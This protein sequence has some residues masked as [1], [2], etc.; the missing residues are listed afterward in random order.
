MISAIQR[1]RAI[2]ASEKL[3]NREEF[4]RALRWLG[5]KLGARYC[6][7]N[8]AKTGVEEVQAA[9]LRCSRDTWKRTFGEP[10]NVA[11]CHERTAACIPQPRYCWEQP[12]TEGAV[13]CIG[14]MFERLP[15][16]SKAIL[17]EVAFDGGDQAGQEKRN[18]VGPHVH[19]Q[20]CA[21]GR[22]GASRPY[23]CEQGASH[24]DSIE[25][26]R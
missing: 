11:E 1:G 15:D 23:E 17:L 14:Y 5:A 25:K 9:V 10:S 19:A 13:K 18:E 26:A 20:E 16:G 21:T 22:T 12:C 24:V 4:L 3:L 2:S 6:R 7:S 8:G